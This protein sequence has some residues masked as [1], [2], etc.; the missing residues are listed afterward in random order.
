MP[1]NHERRV[2]WHFLV[3][4]TFMIDLLTYLERQAHVKLKQSVAYYSYKKVQYI[5]CNILINTAKTSPVRLTIVPLVPQMKKFQQDLKQISVYLKLEVWKTQ[6]LFAQVFNLS[7]NSTHYI[8]PG[9]SASPT[10]SISPFLL[11]SCWQFL[12]SITENVPSL[13]TLK[14]LDCKT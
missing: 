12:L 2:F 7:T 3:D 5:S 13:I 11:C 1:N 4:K 8:I 9:I 6:Q 10:R 14:H